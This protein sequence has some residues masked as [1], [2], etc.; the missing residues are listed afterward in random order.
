MDKSKQLWIKHDFNRN[1][2]WWGVLGVITLLALYLMQEYNFLLFHT[3]V[4]L[5]G[6][7]PSFMIFLV[8]IL[9]WKHLKDNAFLSFIG[10]AFFFV[11]GI[12]LVHALAY[13]G[14]PIFMGFDSNLPTQLWIFGRYI[15]VISLL[16]GCML[17][18]VK[19]Q[20]NPKIVFS[21]YFVVVT[22]TM[23]SI[24]KLQ[25]FPV[26]FI[27]GQG[28]TPFKVISEYIISFCLAICGLIIWSKRKFL[29]QQIA[30][31]LLLSI[32]FQIISEMAFTSF[33]NLYAFPNLMGHYFK[34]VW[35]ILFFAA[36]LKTALF[37]PS[38][39]LYLDLLEREKELVEV[40]QK[41]AEKVNELAKSHAFSKESESR[42]NKALD[43]API[44]IML[45][46]ENGNVLKISKKWT[47]ITGYT[48][49]DIPTVQEWTAKAFGNEH[50][51]IN[52][53]IK[54]TY[55]DI[56]P[57]R[58]WEYKIK[59]KT[60]EERI[61]QYAIANIGKDIEGNNIIFVAVKD[62][63]ERNAFE[64]NI[65]KQ[66]NMRSSLLK[67]LPVGVLMIDAK[68][69]N[70]LVINDA[71]K[72]LLE[73][74]NKNITNLSHIFE[75]VT[76]QNTDDHAFFNLKDMPINSDG[77]GVVEDAEIVFKDGSSK[78]LEIKS[79]QIFDEKG[80]PW[81]III[82]LLDI[83]KRKK[84]EVALIKAK[85]QAEFSSRS[86]S[87]FLA[88]M[89]HEIRTPLNGI[90]GMTQLMAL[91]ELT[92][93]QMEYLSISLSSSEALLT[94]IND[95]LDYS[96]IEAGKMKL[97]KL[98]FKLDDMLKEITSLF[99]PSLLKKGLEMSMDI[100]LGPL[101]CFYGDSFKI[102][103]I[104]TNLIGNAIKYTNE[105]RIQIS[106][107]V[108]SLE[109]DDKVMLEFCVADTGIGIP[110]DNLANIFNSFSQADNSNTRKYGGTGLGLAISKCLV[111]LM[112]GSIWV[113][114][115][116]GVGSKFHFTCELEKG[117]E[118]LFAEEEEQEVNPSNEHKK[119]S[120][121]LVEDDVVSRLLIE[122]IGKKNQ[123]QV[124]T[125]S[126]GKEA[127]AKL[128][129][130]KY[131]LVLMDIQMPVM[132]GIEATRIIRRREAYHNIPIIALTANALKGDRERYLASG[133]D[134]YI[135]K[136]VNLVTL[137]EIV[138]KWS[139][140]LA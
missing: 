41:L 73:I 50:E 127:I 9:V 115:T 100:K 3:V 136:P 131:D 112:N 81:A 124:M 110:N 52:C 32:L 21:I 38:R 106:V 84:D 95:I 61:W 6:V 132:D 99:K 129:E 77:I 24:F 98:V 117:D 46:S 102:R 45:R 67:L 39:L 57:N 128:D 18:P 94:V 44:P 97:E 56:H 105:G 107:K 78:Q 43:N 82:T 96:K 29:N 92:D 74:E 103:Q 54:D 58:E 25:N 135:K 53:V 1:V 19:R 8:V 23:I 79:T 20:I 64:E 47:E 14:M 30:A 119:I 62:I 118:A 65:K 85:E 40:N 68:S 101:N 111:Q 22:M 7:I 108:A 139:N 138:D 126:N 27:E 80:K 2:L 87:Q 60:G 34:V 4:E 91:T 10:I 116:V 36:I 51:K 35:V 28:L 72:V 17:I 83:T 33:S 109:V 123:W 133:M 48:I 93:D 88:N 122:K 140:R 55:H 137:S 16:I 26:C 42:L 90:I 5:L 125:A 49:E 12:D 69:G 113:R 134:D 114:S 13:K 31:L 15:Q 76:I 86:K 104:L 70:L 63:T 11:G 75:Q 121:L 37:S 89:S 71:A 120:I 130:A 66:N 59:T